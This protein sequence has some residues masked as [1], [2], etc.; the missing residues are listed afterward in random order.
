VEES[1]VNH[2]R[3]TQAEAE[4]IE[5]L[6]GD[7]PLLEIHRLYQQQAKSNGWR[8]RSAMA[9]KLRLR[10]TGHHSMVRTGQWLTP[11]GTGEVLGCAGSR[12]AS[13][14]KR[15]DV[16]AIVRPVWRGNARYVSR[17]GWRRLARELPKVLGG[18]D[19]DRLFQLLEDRELADAVAA[20]YPRPLGDYQ[21]RCIETGQRWP[22]A[23][24][25]ASELHVSHTAITLAI[26][27]RRPLYAL[28]MT[29]EALRSVA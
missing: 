1:G 26:R 29:F 19:A 13:W 15:A 12:V 8:Q 4:F 27:R 22:N 5:N 28:G 16:A 7:L 2:P 6:A 10:R 24:K 25:A 9:I 3:W 21:I 23:V 11:N 18:F 20:Q 17:A 14:L